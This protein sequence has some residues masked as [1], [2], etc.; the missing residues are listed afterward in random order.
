MESAKAKSVYYLF[1]AVP[2]TLPGVSP[3]LVYKE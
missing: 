3:I 2:N 1:K